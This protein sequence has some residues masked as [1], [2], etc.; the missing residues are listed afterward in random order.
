MK[1]KLRKKRERQTFTFQ[2]TLKG[3]I[4]RD[5]QQHLQNA[6]LCESVAEIHF[7]DK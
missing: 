4:Q 7:P 6:H 3:M 2:K 5:W 1:K